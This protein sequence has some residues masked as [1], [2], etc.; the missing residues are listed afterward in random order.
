MKS[1]EKGA[2]PRFM[3]AKMAGGYNMFNFNNSNNALTIGEK[4]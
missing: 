3:K 1:W 4:M 2:N